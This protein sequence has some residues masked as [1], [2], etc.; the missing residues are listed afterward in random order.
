MDR[1]AAEQPENLTVQ[2][3]NQLLAYRSNA[4]FLATRIRAATTSSAQKRHANPSGREAARVEASLAPLKATLANQDP[5]IQKSIFTRDIDAGELRGLTFSKR[6]MPVNERQLDRIGRIRNRA[7]FNRGGGAG[8]YTRAISG[9]RL[10]VAATQSAQNASGKQPAKPYDPASD[11]TLAPLAVGSI[12]QSGITLALDAPGA[13]SDVEH[14]L[15]L[16]HNQ[17]DSSGRVFGGRSER[18]LGRMNP[19]YYKAS[20]DAPEPFSV[21]RA[22]AAAVKGQS[23]LSEIFTNPTADTDH[24]EQ[25]W[26]TPPSLSRVKAVVIQKQLDRPPKLEKKTGE[27]LS[28]EVAKRQRQTAKLDE[29]EADILA[30][31]KKGE[32]DHPQ[33]VRE[34]AKVMSAR[35]KMG[36]KPEPYKVVDRSAR[37]PK[38]LRVPSFWADGRVP[39]GYEGLRQLQ[40]TGGKSLDQLVVHVPPTMKRATLPDVAEANL[41]PARRAQLYPPPRT[42][43]PRRNRSSTVV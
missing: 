23:Q 27:E 36:T 13:V 20:T 4:N 34:R 35:R 18:K 33:M 37:L 32:I 7:D 11:E 17:R 42:P 22:T 5:A 28:S 24:N 9:R 1:L 25:I 41:L 8:V 40:G 14:P 29:Q 6:F 16:F 12:G 26:T 31:F 2:D 15:E 19:K 10:T 3:Q 30:R 21:K 38:E 39:K 43:D